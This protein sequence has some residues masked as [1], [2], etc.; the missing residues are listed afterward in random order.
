MLSAV[1]TVVVAAAGAVAAAI[2][3]YGSPVDCNV[4]PSGCVAVDVNAVLAAASSITA[5]ALIFLTEPWWK[6]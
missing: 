2:H 6:R 4:D 5:L 1:I 3:F